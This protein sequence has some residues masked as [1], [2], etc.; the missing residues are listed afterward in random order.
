LFVLYRIVVGLLFYCCLPILLLLVI[1]SGKHRE[2]LKQRFGFY[3]QFSGSDRDKKTVWVHAA[4]VGEVQAARAV[5][6]ELRT[7]L[8][9]ASFVLTTMTV[10]GKRTAESQLE[11][12]VSCLL[13]PLDVP[14]IVSRVVRKIKPDMYICI[15]TELWPLLLKALSR[16]KVQICLV[17]GRMSER[18][19]RSYLKMEWLL[20]KVLK[21]FDRMAV[22]SEKDRERY[23]R[24]GADLRSITVEGNV[25]YDLAI[26]EKSEDIQK[27]YK[28]ILEIGHEEVIIAGSTHTGEEELLLSLYRNLGKEKPI[29]FVIAPRHV[30]RTQDIE[31]ILLS[32]KISYQLFSDLKRE[33]ERSE[34][35]ILIDTMGE[36]AHLYSVADFVFCGGSLVDKGGHNLMEAALWHKAVFFGPSIEDFQDAAELLESVNGGFKIKNIADLEQKLHYFRDHPDEYRKAC[37]Y[38]R[39]IA[40]KQ[41]GCSGRQIDFILN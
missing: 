31:K 9:S 10:H 3:P 12:D 37:R 25:K 21:L 41:Q 18:S 38:A 11:R 23:V 35:L 6:G 8:P 5:I 39:A 19:F 36:L 16:R 1:L 34:S 28:K 20:Q 29:L 24:L 2:G 33:G 7:R 4:S 30:E 15:E 40:I 14:W 27:Y 22:I 17:N 13:A 32:E 26:P